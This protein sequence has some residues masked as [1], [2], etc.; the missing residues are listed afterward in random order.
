MRVFWKR[1]TCWWRGHPN[2]ICY[3]ETISGKVWHVANGCDCGGRRLPM[4]PGAGVVAFHKAY[5]DCP[6]EYTDIF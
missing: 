4:W 2:S 3:I 1:L 6:T 5:E